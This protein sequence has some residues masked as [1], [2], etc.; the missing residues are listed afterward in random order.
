MAATERWRWLSHGEWDGI[1]AASPGP[2]R[3]TLEDARAYASAMR[4]RV[5]SLQAAEAQIDTSF[6]ITTS[7]YGP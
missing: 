3:A 6:G 4:A 2:L 1:V 7:T 5:E